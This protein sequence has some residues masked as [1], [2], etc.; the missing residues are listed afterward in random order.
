MEKQSRIVRFVEQVYRLVIGSLL[1]WKTIISYGG[2]I[3]FRGCC[4]QVDGVPFIGWVNQSR[5]NRKFAP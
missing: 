2:V 4:R 5:K 3:W 1:Y